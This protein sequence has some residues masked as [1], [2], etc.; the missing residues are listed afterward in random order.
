[1]ADGDKIGFWTK[2]M[3]PGCSIC[4]LCIAARKWPKGAFAKAMRA[5]GKL[6]PCCRAYNRLH[7]AATEADTED[8]A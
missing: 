4:P 6:C 5:M 7:A 3:A 1:M 8:R 2:L